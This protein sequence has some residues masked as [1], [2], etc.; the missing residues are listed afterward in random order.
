MGNF[1]RARL[2]RMRGS[3]LLTFGLM[4]WLICAPHVSTGQQPPIKEPVNLVPMW[5]WSPEHSAGNVPQTTC[6]FRKTIELP[7]KYR[8]TIRIAADDEYIVYVNS[9]KIGEGTNAE[10]LTPFDIS[11]YIRQGKNVIAVKVSNR[12][13]GTAGLAARIELELDVF[14]DEEKKPAAITQNDRRIFV[15]NPTWRTNLNTLPMW[16]TPGYRD[17]RWEAAQIFGEFGKTTEAVANAEN[18]GRISAQDLA[19]ES[20][21]LDQ[22]KLNPDNP[23]FFVPENFEVQHVIG[24]EHTGSLLAMT[25]NEFG[26]ILVAQEKGPILLIYDSNDNGVPDA[27]RVACSAVKS[28]QGLVCVS[29]KLFAVGDGPSGQAIYRLDDEDRDGEYERATTILQFE[30]TLGEYGPHGIVLGR[31]GM[32]YVAFGNRAKLTRPFDSSSPLKTVYESELFP[33]ME[34]PNGIDAG[35]RAPCGGVLRLD[36]EGGTVELVAAGMRNPYDLAFDREGELFLLDS[37]LEMD[38]ATPWG[39]STRLLHVVPSGEYGWRSGSAVWLQTWPDNLPAVRDTGRGAPTGCVFYDHTKLPSNFHGALFSCDWAN[40]SIRAFRK[41]RTGA[42]FSA[43]EETFLKGRPLNPTDVEVGPDGW[44]YF[45]TGGRGTRGNVYRVVWKGTPSPE[46]TPDSTESKILAAVR[47]PQ[48]DSA[49]GRQAASVLRQQ[50]EAEWDFEIRAFVADRSQSGLERARA[51][52][53]MHLLGPPPADRELA[54]LVQDPEPNIRVTVARLLGLI[55]NATTEQGLLSLAKDREAWVRRHACESLVRSGRL[56][57]LSTILPMLGSSDRFEAWSSRTVL[58]SN[59]HL[60]ADEA[61]YAQPEL[62][63]FVQTALAGLRAAPTPE[64][65]T[66]LA[67]DVAKLGQD[68]PADAIQSDLLRVLELCITRGKIA[69]NTLPETAI[70]L[71][72]SFPSENALVNRQTVRLLSAMPDPPLSQMLAYVESDAPRLERLDAAFHIAAIRDGWQPNLRARWLQF[73]ESCFLDSNQGSLPLYAAKLADESLASLGPVDQQAILNRAE[74]MPAIAM[75]VMFLLPEQDDSKNL[76]TLIAL[77][78]KIA[79]KRG[80]DFDNL[81]VAIVA[82]L[83]RGG[84][85]E[86]MAYLRSVYDREPRRRKAVAMGLA[87]TPDGPNWDYLVRSIPLLE[88]EPAKEVLAKLTQV[89]YAPEDM[90]HYRQVILCGLRLKEDGGQL[91]ADLL[92]HWV[93]KRPENSGATWNSQLQA[94]QRWFDESQP[95]RPAAA[96]PKETGNGTWTF[97]DILAYLESPQGRNGSAGVGRDLFVKAQC[98]RCHTHGEFGE[99]I[100]PTLTGLE[101]RMDPERLLQA[102]VFPSHDIAPKYT[103]YQ[104]VTKRGKKLEGI[105]I[106]REHDLM[107]LVDREGTATSLFQGDLESKTPVAESLMPEGL[108]NTLSLPEIS[109]LFEFLLDGPPRIATQAKGDGPK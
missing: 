90:E 93:G 19:A 77:D 88:G 54:V 84:N 3:L 91:A 67:N 48:L 37:D 40:G 12:N 76:G 62:K 105:L 20:N 33:R 87:Q 59:A 55:G 64:L 1:V 63:V 23:T 10:E 24:H 13:G 17:R 53:L 35:V 86:S 74:Q 70:W 51:L 28:C 106:P 69:P 29:G 100:G 73:L 15:T 60:L 4:G 43:T 78:R 34:D 80:D 5:I 61:T 81:R 94:W 57:P 56:P 47:Q 89:P 71:A 21:R 68:R 85:P 26:Q 25:F 46:K 14:E 58:E 99:S 18:R 11:K 16:D 42:T 96:L 108:L 83:A 2:V 97:D 79:G 27:A 95:N 6:Y 44:L 39:R 104:V 9:R 102:L 50:G 82:I 72:K 109:N 65:A 31:D 38:S 75:N 30:G 107:T 7:E 36:A 41:Q 98:A 101:E 49:W 32:L 52:E 22:G 8:G 103:V 66:R 92:A 45:T